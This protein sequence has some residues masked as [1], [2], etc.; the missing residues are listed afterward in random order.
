MKNSQTC[1]PNLVTQ[2]SYHTVP[3]SHVYYYAR[4]YL[5]HYL[6][7]HRI[8]GSLH[9]ERIGSFQFRFHP[10]GFIPRTAVARV[11]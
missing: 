1:S 4:H 5:L 10:H 8:I 3:N 6:Q 9:T 7:Y 2:S 11:G